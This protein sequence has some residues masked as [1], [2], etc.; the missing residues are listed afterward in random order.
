MASN[1]YLFPKGTYLSDDDVIPATKGQLAAQDKGLFSRGIEEIKLFQ[2]SQLYHSMLRT[3]ICKLPHV[4]Y[5]NT[6]KI[7][8]RITFFIYKKKLL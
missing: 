4:F 8:I 7:R 5:K 2:T 1:Y 6:K 3:I